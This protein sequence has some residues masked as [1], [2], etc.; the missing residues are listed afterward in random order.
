MPVH[1]LS[2]QLAQRPL[3]M[4]CDAAGPY[5]S[6]ERGGT[7]MELI[8]ILEAAKRKGVSREDVAGAIKDKTIDSRKLG[9]KSVVVKVNRKF[10]DWHPTAVSEKAEK[11]ARRAE[12]ARSVPQRGAQGGHPVAPRR[13]P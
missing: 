5:T 11:R 6:V 12:K 9:A 1:I 2:W 13:T 4:V 7:S 10:E 8:P 3:P